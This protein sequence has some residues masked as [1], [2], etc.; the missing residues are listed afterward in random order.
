M[1][2]TV[3]VEWLVSGAAKYAPFI[4]PR[5]D[6]TQLPRGIASYGATVAGA[7][8]SRRLSDSL[9][10]IYDL[11]QANTELQ[12]TK[13]KV[14]ADLQQTNTRLEQALLEAH[15]IEVMNVDTGAVTV[16][17][18]QEGT[19]P[20]RKRQR[21]VEAAA[22]QQVTEVNQRLVEVKKEKVEAEEAVCFILEEAEKVNE[23][24]QCQL[25]EVTGGYGYDTHMRLQQEKA[26]ALNREV[27]GE[28]EIC[29]EKHEE[30]ACPIGS[31]ARGGSLLAD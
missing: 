29:F 12:A 16:E 4:V 26:K 18:P 9:T 5:S 13:L 15:G 10:V 30:C 25:Q 17:A 11:Q 28:C 3:E 20:P 1:A 19:E 7:E 8:V 21:Q 23:K 2:D 22:T 27:E 6:V 31:R 14:I 24:V